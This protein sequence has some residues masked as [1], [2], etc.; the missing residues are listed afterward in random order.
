[1]TLEF[2]LPSATILAVQ[3]EI[4]PATKHPGFDEDDTGVKTF[5]MLSASFRTAL[6]TLETLEDDVNVFPPAVCICA[7]VTTRCTVY[8]IGG[9]CDCNELI[10]NEVGATVWS[11]LLF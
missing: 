6:T 9:T 7:V 10:G 4:S 1:M 5:P 11:Q 3:D 2:T 8:I